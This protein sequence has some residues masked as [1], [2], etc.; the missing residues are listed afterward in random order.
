MEI[1]TLLLPVSLN[2]FTLMIDNWRLFL[3]LKNQMRLQFPD[4]RDIQQGKGPAPSLL[5]PQ[6]EAVPVAIADGL[7]IYA[8]SRIR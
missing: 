1:I 5:D 6:I 3:K 8:T 2:Y 4:F 7:V